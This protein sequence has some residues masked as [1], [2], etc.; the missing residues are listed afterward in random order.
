MSGRHLDPEEDI[1]ESARRRV[2][3]IVTLLKDRKNVPVPP[4]ICEDMG[5]TIVSTLELIDLYKFMHMGDRK[6]RKEVIWR[7]NNCL[8]W[9]AAVTVICTFVRAANIGQPSDAAMCALAGNVVA[10]LKGANPV[11]APTRLW[12][13]PAQIEVLAQQQFA[14]TRFSTLE[15]LEAAAMCVRPKL[16]AADPL[17]EVP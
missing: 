17:G 1:Y 7:A 8:D 13:T 5:A 4:R 3:A 11:G 16:L 14:A 12:P 2:S 9:F 15:E 6:A 10:R